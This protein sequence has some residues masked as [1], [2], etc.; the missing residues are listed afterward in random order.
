MDPLVIIPLSLFVLS[1]SGTKTAEQKIFIVNSGSSLTYSF[2]NSEYRNII[3]SCKCRNRMACW[4]KDCEL[5]KYTKVTFRTQN[6]FY[7]IEVTI[8]SLSPKD[9]G[10]YYFKLNKYHEENFVLQVLPNRDP[11]A[12]VGK[13]GGSAILSC[14]FGVNEWQKHWCQETQD[15]K[16]LMRTDSWTD[17][18]IQRDTFSLVKYRLKPNDSGKYRCVVT[19]KTGVQSHSIDLQVLK[20]QNG[21][22]V[23]GTVNVMPDEYVII[24]CKYIQEYLDAEK[25]WNCETDTYGFTVID[26]RTQSVLFLK[27]S[28]SMYYI[29]ISCTCRVEKSNQTYSEATVTLIV[30]LKAPQ[31]VNGLEGHSVEIRCNYSSNFV[32]TSKFWCKMNSHGACDIILLSSRSSSQN[33]HRM[34]IIDYYDFFNVIIEHLEMTDAGLYQCGCNDHTQGNVTADV[35]LIIQG[36]QVPSAVSPALTVTKRMDMTNLVKTSAHSFGQS[37]VL[38]GI[39]CLLIVIVITLLIVLLKVLSKRFSERVHDANF[40]GGSFHI[41]NLSNSQPVNHSNDLVALP[42]QTYTP[43]AEDSEDSEDSSST[44]SDSSADLFSPHFLSLKTSLKA[45]D[46]ENVCAENC[47]DYENMITDK[48]QDYVNVG[49]PGNISNTKDQ[50]GESGGMTGKPRESVSSSGISTSDESDS[51]SINYSKV[52]FTKTGIPTR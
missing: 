1:L 38:Y 46:Y 39:I 35:H 15:G 18:H 34:R 49:E 3:E 19:C 20:N 25:T 30:G 10:Q 9:S 12:V 24:A 28:V 43:A 32:I 52:V 44:S 13:V 16:C 23:P 45:E 7:R 5:F 31:Y 41:N 51:E 42:L 27:L 14:T 47:P 50:E 21:L 36:L 17:F 2:V 37:P 29:R 22:S 6:G 33:H 4:S 48:D 26:N 40:G 8:S 11:S